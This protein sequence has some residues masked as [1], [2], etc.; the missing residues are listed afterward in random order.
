MKLS[1]FDFELPKELIAQQPSLKRDHSDLLIIKPSNKIS[2]TKF[3]NIINFL[4]AGDVMVFN[5][6]KVIKAKL[7]LI[8]DANKIEINL[9]KKINP[10]CWR[11]F[12]R[13]AKKLK[14]NDEFNFDSHKIIITKKL[15]MGEI[16]LEFKLDNISVFEFLDKYGEIPLPPYIKREKV[17]STDE[18]RYQTIYNNQAGSIAAP[19]AGLH[20]TKEL[21]TKIKEKGVHIVYV[22]L[23]VGAGTFLPIKTEDINDHTMHSEFY[24]INETTANI[25]NLAKK[26]GRRIIA[27]GTTSIRTLESAA[28]EGGIKSGEFETSIFIK[29]EYNFQIADLLITNFHLPKTTLFMLVCAFAGHEEMINTYNYAIKEKMRFFSYGDAMLLSRNE[30]PPI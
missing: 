23:H 27:V 2:K 4:Q 30:G 29:P 11:A 15:A 13:P 14:E 19:T 26:E 24:Q 28:Y 5:D 9:H 1:D 8:K 10:F 17:E 20:F 25:I 16:E 6:S 21:L 3:Y 7:T 12:A 22:T 18:E